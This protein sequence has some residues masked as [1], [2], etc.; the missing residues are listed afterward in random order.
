MGPC[1]VA[2]SPRQRSRPGFLWGLRESQDRSDWS[3]D[4]YRPIFCL[5]LFG[6]LGFCISSPHRPEKRLHSS[7]RVPPAP[8]GVR[9]GRG[10]SSPQSAPG[11][12]WR[13]AAE[14]GSRAEKSA[15]DREPCGRACAIQGHHEK[16][17][18]QPA[19]GLLRAW[20]GHNSCGLSVL[21]SVWSL[22]S[23]FSRSTVRP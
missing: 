17:S 22:Q 23:F 16:E 21:D 13:K 15:R 3:P 18:L 5:W 9:R 8:P 1:R 4:P 6:V 19:L 12:R 10:K 2:H 7:P 20:A 11:L 14:T